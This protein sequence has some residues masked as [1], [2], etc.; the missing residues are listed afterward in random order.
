MKR[1][2]IASLF[3]LGM[4]TAIHAQTP[5]IT[6]AWAFSH[7]VWEDSLNTETGAKKL[8]DG[9][10]SRGIP[11]EATII[12]SPWSTAYNDFNWDKA[13]Y[14]DPE[15]MLS[16]FKRKDVKVILWLTGVVNQKGKDT[17]LQQCEA[18][19]Y[20][21]SNKL[22]ING[23]EPHEWWK[24]YGIHIDF[25][26]PKAVE[27]WHTQLD[28]VFVDGVYGWKVDQGEFWFG[29]YLQTSK[30]TMSNA[31]FRP[32]YYDAMYDYTTARNPEG[33]IIARP[34]SHQGGYF[35]SPD[36]M[37]LGWCGDFSGDWNGLKL[38]IDNIYRSALRGYASPACEVAGFFMRRAG[39][40]EFVRYAQFG[41]MTAAMI[42]GGENGAFTNHLP[43]FHGQDVEDIYRFCVV[44]HDELVPYLFSTVV[45]AHLHGGSLL[46]NVSFSEESHQVGDYIFTKAITSAGSGPVVF[47]LPSEGTWIDF[48]TGDS[49]A[50]DTRISRRYPLDEFPLFIRKGAIIPMD[51]RSGTTGIGCEK[52]EGCRSFLICPNGLSARTLHLPQGDGTEY[53]DCT[54]SF[55]EAKGEL[56]LKSDRHARY[57]FI[58]RNMPAVSSVT[59]AADWQYDAE[60]KELLI[61]AEGKDISLQID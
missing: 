5:P 55:D 14:P 30:G 20:V 22:G 54:V 23:S 9:Y 59:D 2:V 48:W 57:A 42:N 44:L 13:R 17:P 18:Y 38:Q 35:A 32:Y 47:R 25:T 46:K 53:Y 11:V 37:N 26:N 60:R 21:R 45:D 51:I 12:D 31:E 15:G 49:F 27:W 50:P 33:I 56:R 7:I 34:Y 3:G 36:K 1:I 52:L 10:L 19:D 4:L 6:P 29:D 41:C 24:G 43:W 8:V 16:Y 28:K 39:K 58:L 40:E 61:V